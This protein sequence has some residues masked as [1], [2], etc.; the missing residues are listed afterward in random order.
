MLKVT[1]CNS[2]L[3]IFAG[4]LSDLLVQG[5]SLGPLAPFLAAL[6][7][8]SYTPFTRQNPS[9]PTHPDLPFTEHS[10]GH[11]DQPPNMLHKSNFFVANLFS[12]LAWQPAFWWSALV[13]QRTMAVKRVLWLRNTGEESSIETFWHFPLSREGATSIF[14]SPTILRLGIVQ[15]L[16][17]VGDQPWLHLLSSNFP[18][19]YYTHGSYE[20]MIFYQFCL[21]KETLFPGVHVHFCLPLDP[22]TLCWKPFTS[23]WQ[24]LCSFHGEH[25]IPSAWCYLH[26]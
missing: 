22:Y 12:S 5:L 14:E 19:V 1:T 16:V 7:T 18:T 10:K 23:P 3:A 21:R 11:S 6:V 2:L 4:L 25:C 26:R 8:Y 24:D 9:E 13:G 17:E 15:A 20:R